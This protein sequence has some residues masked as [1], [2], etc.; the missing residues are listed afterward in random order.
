M[1]TSSAVAIAAFISNAV[2]TSHLC[3]LLGPAYPRPANI[4]SDPIMAAA[5]KNISAKLNHAI[6]SGKLPVSLSAQI[7]AD[8][9]PHSFYRF[10]HT[11]SSL[12]RTA[13]V[14]KVDEDTV[15]RI[16]SVSKLWTIYLFMME[17][18]IT[19]FEE[20]V[21]KYVP[22]LASAAQELRSNQTAQ[23]DVIDNM[24]WDQV[25]IGELAS[26]TAGIA[27]D[28]TINPDSFYPALQLI[29][30]SLSF[31]DAIGDLESNAAMAEKM[32]F[33]ALPKSDQLLCKM[34]NL[35][36]RKRTP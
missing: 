5:E 12:N 14:R 2:A 6:E 25:T 7:F 3:P 21:I 23:E 26:H 15:F 18:G 22:E 17:K 20:P 35:C 1:R 29:N 9:E 24:Q 13:G 16:G 4:R 32:G 34:G 19:Y 10:S 33:P 8:S 11:D 31:L 30:R 28:C 27:R 36:T